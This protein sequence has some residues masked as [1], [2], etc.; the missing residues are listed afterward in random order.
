MSKTPEEIAAEKA[1]QE[2]LEQEKIE[3]DLADRD[4]REKELADAKEARI[5]AEAQLEVFKTMQQTKVENAGPTQ[6]SAEQWTQFE[7]QTG[8]T[9]QQLMAMDAIGRQ[10]A[11]AAKKDFDAKVR[12]AEERAARA[13]QELNGFKNE[14]GTDSAKRKFYADKPALARYETEINDFLA[15]FPAEMKSDPEKLKG[16]LVKAET[17]IKGKLGDKFMRG[18]DTKGS[19]RFNRG[20]DDYKD[21]DDAEETTVDTSGLPGQSK[22]LVEN[23]HSSTKDRE[24]DWKKNYDGQGIKLSNRDEFEAA[25]NDMRTRR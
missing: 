22:R 20:G 24:A 12:Q 1:E 8:M 14:R 7:E 17:Y 3:K 25:K 21:G 15:D 5:K 18:N 13:E 2:R 9:K 6:L 16:L 23:L 11:D 10:H 19:A 4:A